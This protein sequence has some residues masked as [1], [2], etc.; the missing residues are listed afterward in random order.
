MGG[1]K[2]QSKTNKDVW[3]LTEPVNV[4]QL[5]NGLR[6]HLSFHLRDSNL[7][8]SSFFCCVVYHSAVEQYVAPGDFVPHLLRKRAA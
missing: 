2:A 7:K 1:E 4:A 8:T 3:P 5:M 6:R